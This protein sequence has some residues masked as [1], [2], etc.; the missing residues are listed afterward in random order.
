MVKKLLAVLSISLLALAACS[1]DAAESAP[2]GVAVD[3]ETASSMDGVE[4]VDQLDR[5][6]RDERP[7][8]L[9][10]SVRSDSVLLQ[11]TQTGD[12]ATVEL[13]DDQF[14]LSFAPYLSSTHDCFYHSL[15]TCTGELFNEDVDVT[16][17][18]SDGEVLVDDTLTMFD[19]GF[20]GVWLPADIEATLT[21][22][23]DG[24]T[25]TTEIGTGDDDPT[26]LTTLRLS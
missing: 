24:K 17:V 23:Y 18:A 19:N 1:N 2:T 26:C 12:E 10:A 9:F 20:V 11:D 7:T 8:D 5:M 4:L 21:V 16:I 22:D 15:T 6:T 3:F 14:Y 25:G 13:P